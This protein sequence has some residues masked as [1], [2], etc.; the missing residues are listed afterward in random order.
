MKTHKSIFESEKPPANPAEAMCKF[1]KSD[2]RKGFDY[3]NEDNW[4]VELT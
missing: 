1:L 3:R 2:K 4:F